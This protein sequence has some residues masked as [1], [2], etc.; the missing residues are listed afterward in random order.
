MLGI[1]AA[2]ELRP[3]LF[4]A[5]PNDVRYGEGQYLS[6]FLPGTKTP[7]QL[8]REFLGQP[9]QGSRFTH[10]VAIDVSGLSIVQGRDGVIVIPGN[11]PL[12]LVGRIVGCGAINSWNSEAS[13]GLHPS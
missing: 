12:K 2:N 4:A 1:I 6:D 10:F 9:F 11:R 5:N 13:N 7:A 3:S 8:S